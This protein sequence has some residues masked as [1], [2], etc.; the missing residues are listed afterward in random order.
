MPLLALFILV[1]ATLYTDAELAP[2]ERVLPEKAQ[3]GRPT[4]RIVQ[5]K[6]FTVIGRSFKPGEQIRVSTNRLR[7][8]VVAG[9]RGGFKVTFPNPSRCNGLAVT[10]VGSKGSRAS[11]SFPALDKATCVGP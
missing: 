8:M 7:R 1:S 11:I 10:A 9:S 5:L 4:L 3:P 6:P 2:P